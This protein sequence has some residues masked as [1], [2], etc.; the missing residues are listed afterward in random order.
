VGQVARRESVLYKVQIDCGEIRDTGNGFG[1]SNCE[2]CAVSLA[3]AVNMCF[4]LL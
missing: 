3:T 2:K 4:T 1:S